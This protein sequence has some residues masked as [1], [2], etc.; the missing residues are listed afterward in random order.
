MSVKDHKMQDPIFKPG[1]HTPPHLFAA[2]SFYM[3]TAATY[4]QQ[5]VIRSD[6]RKKEW[7]NAFLSACELYHWDG[8]AWVVLDN[9]YHAMVKSTSDPNTLSK[10]IGSVH[11]FT[12]RKWN[13][14]DGQNGRQVWW[15]FWDTCIRSDRDKIDRLKYVFWNPVKHG[16]VDRP[17]E[18]PYSNYK[19]FMENQLDIDF[20]GTG[21]VTDAPEY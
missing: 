3:L 8:F 21:A 16:L 7:I 9:H 2:D 1:S 12:A 19:E 4:Q 5:P 6:R 20:S 15:N 14:E 18:Y 10:F 17:E 13:D 11:K